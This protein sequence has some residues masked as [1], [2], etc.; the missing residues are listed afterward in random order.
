MGICIVLSN[1]VRK[2][3]NKFRLLSQL[4]I[5][6]ASHFKM[7]L[8]VWEKSEIMT[9]AVFLPSYSTLFPTLGLPLDIKMDHMKSSS[10]VY[11]ISN[12]S[13]L[14]FIYLS[15]ALFSC[16]YNYKNY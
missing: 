12:L 11:F 1:I 3:S 5:A 9:S 4:G 10:L 6:S 8:R 13:A 14:T 16:S 7:L 15:M 2:T